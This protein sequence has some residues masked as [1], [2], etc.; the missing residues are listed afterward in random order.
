[1]KFK[2]LESKL[3]AELHTSPRAGC[4]KRSK[5]RVCNDRLDAAKVVS[6]KG[7]E[8]IAL[9]AALLFADMEQLADLDHLGDL[10]G[11]EFDVNRQT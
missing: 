7:V 5:T 3:D 8:D 2:T 6:V 4:R 10:P 11:V 1:M 9:K